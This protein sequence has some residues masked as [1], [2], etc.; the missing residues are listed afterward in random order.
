[1][2]KSSY[3][4]RSNTGNTHKFRKFVLYGTY[5]SNI[6]E[7]EYILTRITKENVEIHYKKD[8]PEGFVRIISKDSF[9]NFFT[10]KQPL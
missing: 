6:D 7:K 8:Y 9:F 4:S 5:E 10:I 1:M 2:N 3:K